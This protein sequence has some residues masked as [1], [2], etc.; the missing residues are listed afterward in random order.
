MRWNIAG[1]GPL[2]VVIAGGG[3]AALEAGLGLRDLAHRKVKVT[4][5]A[6]SE[7]FVYRPMAVAGTFGRG[8]PRRLPLRQVANDIGAEFVQ[9]TLK[10]VDTAEQRVQLESGDDVAY[11]ALV[12]TV[13]AQ[14]TAVLPDAIMMPGPDVEGHLDRLLHD[15]GAGV[16]ERLAFAIP[17]RTVWPLAIYEVALSARAYAE[18]AHAELAISIVTVEDAPLSLFGPEVSSGVSE[19][20]SNA[21]I[22][23]I[24]SASAEDLALSGFDRVFASPQLVGPGIAGLPS[25][26]AGFLPVDAHGR[27]S[28]VENVYAA[29]DATDF[30]LKFGGISAQQADAVAESIAALAGASV[31]PKPLDP[32]IHGMLLTGGRPRYL[33]LSARTDGKTAINSRISETSES[34]PTAKI[35]ARYLAPYLDTVWGPVTPPGVTDYHTSRFTQR[36]ESDHQD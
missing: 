19:L 7:E 15:I 16:V 20:L 27:V 31:E 14:P 2:N 23:T 26:S 5:V 34:S 30:P 21:G 4:L 1:R 36:P 18:R 12:I 24:T 25:D 10:A 6:S 13:G 8:E 9:D 11:D 28:G 29:G 33:H 17:S 35:A 32:E 3:V 22:E